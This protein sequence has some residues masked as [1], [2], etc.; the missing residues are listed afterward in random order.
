VPIYEYQCETCGKV[1]DVLILNQ[2]QTEKILCRS[3]HGDHLVR[4]LSRVVVHKTERQRLTEFDSRKPR[5]DSFYKDDRN[6]GLWAKKRMKELGVDLGSSFDETVE[7]ARTG[8]ALED[9]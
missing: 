8:K 7:K 1:T 4:I 3:C 2:K 9:M 6:V 5:D